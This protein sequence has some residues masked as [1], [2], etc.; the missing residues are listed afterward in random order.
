M[1]IH[2]LGIGGTGMGSLAGLLTEAGHRVSGTDEEIYP[3]M[4]DQLA[5]LK[6]T[7]FKGYRAENIDLAQPDMA[8]IGNVIRKDNPEAQEVMRRDIPFRSMP[9]AVSELFLSNR[10]PLVISGTHGKTTSST[11]AA[12]LLEAAD[13]S[14]GF[15]IGGVGK[16]LGRSYQLGTGPLFVIEGDEYDSAFFDKGPKFLHYRPQALIVTSIEFDHADIYADVE[17]ITK[18]FER[19]VPLVPPDGVLVLNA[20]DD[21][22]MK[23]AKLARSRVV[24]YGTTRS[25]DYAPSEVEIGPKGTSF[26]LRQCPLRLTLPMWGDHNLKNCMGVLAALIESGI[27]ADKLVEGLATFQGVKRRQ[28]LLATINGV[29]VIDDFAHHPTAVA[30][31]IDSMRQR[32]PEGRIWAIFEPR[33]NTSRR[34]FF[35][36]E[37]VRALRR[38]DRVIIASPFKAEAIPEAERFDARGIADAIMRTGIDSHHIDGIDH[39]VEFVIRG[40]DAGDVLLIMSNGGFGGLHGKLVEALGKRRTYSNADEIPYSKVPK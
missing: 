9:A 37:Y 5:A 2:M 38:A 24:T 3:P 4:S 7:P 8:I 22:V 6:I 34:N 15:L 23:L 19:L 12:W 40:V 36:R 29:S 14:P 1:N 28:E 13:E 31:T 35:R 21:R 32:F 30:T 33:S 39:I 20:E 17:H 18:S 16:N 11:L 26:S 25:A 10:T 27:P